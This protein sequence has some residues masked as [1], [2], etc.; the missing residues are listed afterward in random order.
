M[1][2]VAGKWKWMLC[3]L[4][5]SAL[6]LFGGSRKVS[7]DPVNSAKCRVVFANASGVVSTSTYRN[8][9]KVVKS[10]EWIKLPEFSQDG[11]ECYWVLKS[12]DTSR[13]Y[14][15]GANFRVTKNTKFCLYRYKLY[16]IR[17]MTANGKEY[18][19]SRQEAIAGEY[20]TLP[21]VASTSSYQIVGW[22]TSANASTYS[23][24]GSK[25]RVT[26]NMKFY[27]VMQKVTGVNLRTVNGTLWRVLPT[28]GTSAAVFPSV[29][30]GSG[31]MCLGWSR[32]RGKTSQPEYYAGDK[33]PTKSGNYYMVVF[34]Q[35]RDKAP[36]YL[37]TPEKYGMVYFVGDSRTAGMEEVLGSRVPSNVKFIYKGGGGLS[38]LQQTTGDGGYRQLLLEL[39]KQPKRMKKAVVVNLGVNDYQNLSAYIQYM[40]RLA[41]NLRSN[42]NCTMYYMSVNPVN[43]A[44]IRSYGAGDRTENQ[45]ALFNR[46]I[47]QYLCSGNNRYFTYI[48]TCTNLQK[49]GWISNRHN[50]GI[51]DGLHYSNETYL[52]IYDY[53]IRFLNR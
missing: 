52:R 14:F 25:I 34:T 26:G 4:M 29:N 46:R 40:K 5:L 18:V 7:A 39:K 53:C 9:G 30:L 33:I 44:M 32:T 31:N 21:R 23:N 20:I 42:Y 36:A 1:R 19:S 47:Y 10:G 6:F 51:Y 3:L 12:G 48:N 35:S 17:F 27:A 41:I 16:N 15:P 49:Y 13:K 37:N 43:S 28:N 11:Y 38:W 8:W 50:A 2:Q 45:V 24:A 22:K